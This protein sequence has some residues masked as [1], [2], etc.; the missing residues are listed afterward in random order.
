MLVNILALSIV[1]L[2]PFEYVNTSGVNVKV[3]MEDGMLEA[4]TAKDEAVKDSTSKV[5]TPKN[6]SLKEGKARA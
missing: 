6:E 1:V 3:D 5:E 4:G 2:W